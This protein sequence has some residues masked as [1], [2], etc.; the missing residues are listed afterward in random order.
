MDPTG[1]VIIVVALVGGLA[2]VTGAVTAVLARRRSSANRIASGALVELER[3]AGSALVRT[4]ERIRLADDELGFATAEFGEADT[5]E[6]AAALQRAR[7]RLA[8]AFHLNQ[9]LSDAVPDTDD[10]R[11]D[12]AE[13]IVSL[14]ASAEAGLREQSGAMA[15]RRA[16]ARRTPSAIDEIR[17]TI[18]RVRPGVPDAKGTLARLAED[19]TDAA[20]EPVVGNPQQADQLLA[21][22][23]RSAA[24]AE[25]RLAAGRTAEAE[26][27]VDAAAETLRRAQALLAS[28]DEFEV[29]ALQAEATL[30]AMVAESRAELA[31]ART[32][33]PI[34]RSARIEAAV[35]ELERA[36]AALPAPGGRREPVRSLSAIRAANAA[37][38]DAVAE[39]VERAERRERLRS[40]LVTAI[41]DAERQLSAARE[42]IADYRAP[43]GPDARTR[44]AEAERELVAMTQERAPEQAIARARRAASLAADAAAF[45]RADLA[46]P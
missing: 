36:L 35:V 9:Q 22:A 13:R 10:E 19:Y 5:A 11:R 26:K 12:W 23:E 7:A 29:E 25:S 45:A 1:V 16:A 15:A 2:A 37:L 17:A 21:F 44:L 46:T 31:E 8:E 27:A 41:D 24:V 34:E 32:L 39:R 43:I 40:R 6:F 42:L 18:R 38:D 33:R 14:C 4:D 20:L 3:A 30:A 28:V